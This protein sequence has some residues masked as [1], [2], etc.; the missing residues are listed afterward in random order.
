MSQDL[1]AA[2]SSTSTILNVDTFSLSN[3]AQG[4]YYGWAQE[5]MSLRGQNKWCYCKSSK[6]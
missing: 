5:G 6:H 3:E 4:Q 1:S 2:Y